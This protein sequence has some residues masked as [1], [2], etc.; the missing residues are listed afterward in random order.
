MKDVNGNE[1]TIL[2]FKT[3]TSGNE[4]LIDITTFSTEQLISTIEDVNEE[5]KYR[6]E[7]PT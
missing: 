3:R 7:H 1:G 4:G 6:L 5:M 2:L